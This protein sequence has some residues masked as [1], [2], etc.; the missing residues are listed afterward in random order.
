MLPLFSIMTLWVMALAE[1]GGYLSMCSCGL[2]APSVSAF[3]PV[4]FHLHSYRVLNV[5]MLNVRA[6][7]FCG[8][9]T[10]V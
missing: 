6:D 10:L 2:N 5:S 3:F 7:A 9:K 4:A 8:K 1:S